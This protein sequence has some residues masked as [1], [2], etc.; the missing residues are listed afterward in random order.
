MSEQAYHAFRS[1]IVSPTLRR[2]WMDAYKQR[3]WHE[4]EPPWTQAT[5]DDVH[6]VVERLVPDHASLVID[7]G[8][9]SGCLSRYI[10]GN[11]EARVV[12]IDANPFAVR[13]AQERAASHPARD[14]VSFR[15]A[16]VGALPW[17]DGTFDGAAS[18]DVLLMVPDKAKAV[19]EIARVLKP[20]ARFVGTTFEFR[21]PSVAVGAPAFVDYP[22]AF[23]AAD[24]VMELY[25]EAIDWRRHLEHVTSA[26]ISL[27][28]E[29][30]EEIAPE[31]M[32]RVINW[33]RKRPAELAESRRTRFCAVR[34]H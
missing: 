28:R 19:Q 9:G 27:E 8:C 14:R 11:S 23:A 4:C 33:A 34:K 17:P 24:L 31:A 3:F 10:L 20:G 7:I 22:G 12:G 5:A 32:M 29:L 6:F 16:D 15:L 26:I 25:E 2:I 1:V 21:T 13:L 30:S 18:L